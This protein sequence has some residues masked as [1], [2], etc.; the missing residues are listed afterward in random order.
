MK[1]ETVDTLANVGGR[2]T[3]TGGGIAGF[4]WILSS[5]FFGLIGCLVAVIGLL[6]NFHFRREANRRHQAEFE[7]R[8]QEI[9]QR[10]DLM[11]RTGKPLPAHDDPHPSEVEE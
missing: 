9:L 11:R 6:I 7:L 3:Y 8:R 1:N 10:I 5:E 2:I 4:S